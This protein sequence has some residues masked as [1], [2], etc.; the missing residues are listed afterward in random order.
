MDFLE[1]AQ[2]SS[3]TVF[4]DE[5]EPGTEISLSDHIWKRKRPSFGRTFDACRAIFATGW[6]KC[7]DLLLRRANEAVVFQQP[8]AVRI[9]HLRGLEGMP[10]S[11]VGIMR[12]VSNDGCGGAGRRLNSKPLGNLPP[13]T[14]KAQQVNILRFGYR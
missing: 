13:G 8:P 14:C 5:I 12:P 4:C 10:D 2:K 11:S 9:I 1:R 7:T 3:E 6:R